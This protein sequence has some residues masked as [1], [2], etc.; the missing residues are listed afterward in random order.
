MSR[1]VCECDEHGAKLETY[2]C[3]HIGDAACE[4]RTVGFVCYPGEGDDGLADAWCDDCEAFLAANGGEWVDEK[5]DV[6][7]GLAILCSD[8]YLEAKDLAAAAGRLRV[9]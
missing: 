5:V 3:K 4:N 7:D 6:P 2:V 9:L 1:D 8:C